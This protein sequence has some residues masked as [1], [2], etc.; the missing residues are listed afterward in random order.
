MMSSAHLLCGTTMASFLAGCEQFPGYCQPLAGSV[1]VE[2]NDGAVLVLNM[3]CP[4]CVRM[5]VCMHTCEFTCKC[6]WMCG[7]ERDG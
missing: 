4:V 1:R 2:V 5:C 3:S 6:V 7:C